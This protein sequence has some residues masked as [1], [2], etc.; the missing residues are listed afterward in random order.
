MDWGAEHLENEFFQAHHSPSKKIRL[1]TQ[2]LDQRITPD[3][4]FEP[5]GYG[6]YSSIE[7]IY[8]YGNIAEIEAIPVE[9]FFMVE[10]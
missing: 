7:N 9:N 2:S 4:I 5:D 8:N 6:G 1:S 3:Y 10:N